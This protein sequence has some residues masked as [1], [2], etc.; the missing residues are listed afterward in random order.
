[1]KTRE[2]ILQMVELPP[3]FM[4]KS[5]NSIGGG[6]RQLVSIAR[7]LCS[8][9]KFIPKTLLLLKSHNPHVFQAPLL[10]LIYPESR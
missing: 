1:M 2:E 4:Y 10:L 3:D 6:E 5:P 8:N 7:A 9:P